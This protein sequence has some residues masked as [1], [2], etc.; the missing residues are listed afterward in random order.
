MK[1]TCYRLLL[2]FFMGYG[3][4]GPVLAD[5]FTVED[6]RIEGIQRISAGTVFN[7]LPVRVGEEFSESRYAESVRALYESGYFQ[8]IR[9]E[10]QGN[11]LIIVMEERPAI[12]SVEFSGNKEIG[13]EELKE[14]LKGIGLSEGEVFRQAILETVEDEMR[15]QYYANGKYSVKITSTATP[16]ERNR[17]SIQIDISEGKV[18]KIK[19]INIVGNTVFDD[20]ELLDKFELSI[21]AWYSLFSKADQYSKQKLSSDLETLSSHYLDRGYLKFNIDSTQVSITPDKQDIYITIN[22]TEGGQ[23]RVS[24]IK[25][26]GKLLHVDEK[27]IKAVKVR[28]GDIFSRRLIVESTDSL[29]ELMANDGYAFANINAIPEVNE[30]DNTVSLTFFVDPGRRIYVR[31]I[32]VSG[33]SKTQD[34]VVRRELRQIENAWMSTENIEKSTT[35]LERLGYFSQVNVET[36]SVPGNPD[37]VDVN[38]S[39]AEQPSG[40]L[41]AGVGYS[42][43]QGLLLSTSVTQNNFLGSGKRFGFNISTR[44]AD[45]AYGLNYNNPYYTA[46]GVSRGF[47]IAL[48]ERNAEALGTSDYTTDQLLMRV[49]YGIP[50]SETNTIFA[51]FGYERLD[52][53]PAGGAPSEI[54]DFAAEHGERYQNLVAIASWVNDKR[55][56]AALLADRGNYNLIS[57]E[58]TFPGSGLEYY[59]LTYRHQT[60]IP[61]S[62]HTTLLLNGEL[63]FGDGYGELDDLPF[64]EH[65][66]AGGISSVRGFRD[67]TL[68]PRD[69]QGE[70]FG[71]DFRVIG[72]IEFLMPMPFIEEGDRAW[73][74][75]PFIDMGNVFASPGDFETSEMR[76]SAGIGMRWL[77]PIGP[78][79]ISFARP[80]NDERGDELQRFQFTFGATY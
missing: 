58:F 67:N 79:K 12:A 55:N 3:I 15:R 5:S 56:R 23:Y 54:R 8:D 27:L 18:A 44:D 68:G 9:L 69:S 52:L 30:E 35:R 1:L 51:G 13:T 36:P 48:K 63:G 77:S 50:V 42:Q 21:P 26:S 72:N 11:V 60:Y 80:L 65:F 32:N 46:D 71:G 29:T 73:R 61:L 24:E 37:Q 62:D 19:E 76:Y 2:I 10:R 33:N 74:F 64:L 7:Y 70:P 45:T 34:E 59:R 6:I 4:A 57:G 40:S 22:I 47:N 14:A 43:S 28:D 31:R 16:L 38:Y 78:L 41:T 39:V 17:V 49:N 53:E 25:V 66:Y 75:A 20:E